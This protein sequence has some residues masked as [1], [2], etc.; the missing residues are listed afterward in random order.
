LTKTR[1]TGINKLMKHLTRII[2]IIILED[3]G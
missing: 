1:N 2:S 3:N